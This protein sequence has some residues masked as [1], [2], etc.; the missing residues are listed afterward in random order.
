MKAIQREDK[1]IYTCTIHQSRGS[2]ST[3]EKSKDIDV[4]VIG[5]I[6]KNIVS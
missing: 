6:R 2:Q 4:K 3:S 1:G 5:K